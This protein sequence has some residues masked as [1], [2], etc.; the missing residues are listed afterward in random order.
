MLRAGDELAHS[1][2]GN[3]NAYAQDN[4]VSWLT[5]SSAQGELSNFI[6]NLSQLRR[7]HPALRGE[8]APARWFAPAGHEM[9]LV[10]WQDFK[11]CSLAMLREAAGER[12]LILFHG[13]PAVQEFC[14][15]AGDW[16]TILCSKIQTART[17]HGGDTVTAPA[18]S[19]M[20]L[21][22]SQ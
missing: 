11:L 21:Q 18:N 6:A 7:S 20:I 9:G 16:L 3:N 8:G 1:Q 17:F 5:W 22:G 12:F 2:G 4:A 14:L 13:G 19:L 15:P 10:D